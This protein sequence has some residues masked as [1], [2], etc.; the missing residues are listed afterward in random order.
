MQLPSHLLIYVYTE[1]TKP[2]G[3]GGC[4]RWW[5]IRKTVITDGNII[6]IHFSHVQRTRS[7]AASVAAA[8]AVC[9]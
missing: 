2:D 9:L 6:Q 8:A 4:V 7:G 3:G 1:R 5:N